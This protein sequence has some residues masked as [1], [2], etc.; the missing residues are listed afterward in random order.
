M[1]NGR[2]DKKIYYNDNNYFILRRPLK[3]TNITL[4]TKK[5]QQ[6]KKALKINDIK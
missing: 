4:P 6:N 5:K 3:K 1:M 2:N